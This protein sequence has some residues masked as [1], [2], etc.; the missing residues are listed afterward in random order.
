[1]RYKYALDVDGAS[2][3]E[4]FTW[5][6]D[7][8]L[9]PAEAVLYFRGCAFGMDLR[10]ADVMGDH[11]FLL[12]DGGWEELPDRPSSAMDDDLIWRDVDREIDSETAEAAGTSAR[13]DSETDRPTLESELARYDTCP[14]CAGEPVR[15]N[16][17]SLA[18]TGWDEWTLDR[19]TLTISLVGEPDHEENMGT[20]DVELECAN[21]HTW[22]INDL[23]ITLN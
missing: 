7:L 9:E 23:G 5:E 14:E 20:Y 1:M 2:E 19:D 18:L 15:I 16:V 4:D 6:G 10:A 13:D 22:S 12:L 11:L 21:V 8:N 3:R 17:T